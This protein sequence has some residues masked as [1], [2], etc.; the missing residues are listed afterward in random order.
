MNHYE[1]VFLKWLHKKTFLVRD[2]DWFQNESSFP[3]LFSVAHWLRSFL[4]KPYF[5]PSKKKTRKKLVHPSTWFS[6]IVLDRINGSEC[7]TIVHLLTN[8]LTEGLRKK[9]INESLPSFPE[10]NISS[11][12]L[13]K[14]T[15]LDALSFRKPPLECE[16]VSQK[17][18]L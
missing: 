6:K 1:W 11:Y 8:E 14:T 12:L 4:E 3:F 17:T 15:T 10:K 5:A 9:W 18:K 2:L 7:G 13:S 16:K